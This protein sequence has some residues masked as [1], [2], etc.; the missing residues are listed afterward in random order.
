MCEF[1]RVLRADGRLALVAMAEQ[2]SA[3]RKCGW[4]CTGTLRSWLGGRPVES[5]K[6]LRESGWKVEREEQIS[7]MGSRS[8]VAVARQH[9]S[10][11]AG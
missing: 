1:S 9:T 5:A 4:L 11:A 10:G 7:Q 8:A 3:F 6:W 2:G